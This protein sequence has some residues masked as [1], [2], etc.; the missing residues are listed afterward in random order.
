[1]NKQSLK[2]DSAKSDLIKLNQEK[3]RQELINMFGVYYVEV[4]RDKYRKVY[5]QLDYIEKITEKI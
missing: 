3:A 4:T 5:K 1:M 2:I